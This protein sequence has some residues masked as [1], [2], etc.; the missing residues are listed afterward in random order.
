M[1]DGSNLH[2]LEHSRRFGENL[3]SLETL[4]I[5]GNS[6]LSMAKGTNPPHCCNILL[7]PFLLLCR[8][9]LSSKHRL[10]NRYSRM[11]GN[12]TFD[13]IV[14]KDVQKDLSNLGAKDMLH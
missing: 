14:A 7:Y 10:R 4:N 6:A 11:K 8:F 12:M 13:D 2:D 3:E 9:F 1:Y 5:S